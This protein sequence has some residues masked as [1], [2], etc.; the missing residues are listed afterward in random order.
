MKALDRLV[1]SLRVKHT[2][3]PFQFAYQPL[4]G[5]GNAV[6]YLLQCAHPHLDG[7]DGTVKLFLIFF[8]AS[9]TIQPFLLSEKLGMV[10]SP[11]L[12]ALYISD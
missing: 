12:F 1:L 8:S 5:V 3:H 6:I 10:L 9:N 4:T 11:F 2:F 7:T